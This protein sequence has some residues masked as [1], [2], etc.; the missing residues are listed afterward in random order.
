MGFKRDIVTL[1]E[2]AGVGTLNTTIFTTSRAAL[3]FL[4]SGAALSVIETGGTA[5]LRTHT[6]RVS[7]FVQAV[8]S[9][10]YQRPSALIMVRS[11]KSS[12]AEAMAR[13]AY[14]AL[15]GFRNGFINSG[16]YQEI[17]PMQEP[18]DPGGPDDAGFYRCNFN[19]TAIK[20]PS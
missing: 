17:S 2:G 1:L 18:Y 8:T 12:E 13:A 4:A 15:A 19:V 16:W 9:P 5:P 3:P 7:G 14:D 11:K 10:A 20:R 6:S